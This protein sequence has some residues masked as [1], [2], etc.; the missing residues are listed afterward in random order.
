M[1]DIA[2]GEIIFERWRNE[3]VRCQVQA[4]GERNPGGA[5]THYRIIVEMF[6]AEAQGKTEE[7]IS[8]IYVVDRLVED[9]HFQ[10]GHFSDVGVNGH[11]G[12]SFMAVLAHRMRGFAK[13]PYSCQENV[14]IA[15]YLQRAIQKSDRRFQKRQKRNVAGKYEK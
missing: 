5:H 11:L 12:D 4:I 13:G 10:S 9:I 2:Q 14:D 8:E 15:D 3:C 7:E 1:S 6:D